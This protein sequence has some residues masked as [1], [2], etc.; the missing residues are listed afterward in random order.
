MPPS[1]R[2]ES[3]S[4]HSLFPSTTQGLSSVSS[5]RDETQT[6][7]WVVLHNDIVLAR[8]DW[9]IHM[10]RIFAMLVSQISMDDEQFTMQR[11]RVKDL[12][13]LAQIK[14]EGI[15]SDIADAAQRLVREPFEFRTEDHHYEGYPIFSVCKYVRGEGCVEAHFNEKARPYLLK[16]SECFTRYRLRQV[17]KLSTAYAVRFYQ[18]AKM[19]ERS[20]GARRQTMDI[21]FFRE[22][23]LIEEKYDR[24]SDVVRFVIEPSVQEVNEKTDTNLRCRTI[25]KGGSKYGKPLEL[26]WT[27]WPSDTSEPDGAVPRTNELQLEPPSTA[28][29][30]AAK[31]PFETWFEQQPE[32]RQRALTDKAQE[33]VR[34]DVAGREIGER[35]IEARVQM[36]L[37]E[38]TKDLRRSST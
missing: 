11:I 38:I 25:R 29:R 27:V 7:K 21:P 8:V 4:Q 28:G 13:D 18:I 23:F 36:K 19:I 24:Y 16:L 15:H 2:S 32:E 37:R 12:V 9:D 17:M 10:N 35:A 20:E 3:D 5:S 30:E 33:L 14:R 26:E 22:L 6:K 34:Q 31:D 1:P